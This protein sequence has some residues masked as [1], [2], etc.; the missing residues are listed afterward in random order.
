MTVNRQFILG[1]VLVAVGCLWLFLILFHIKPLFLSLFFLGVWLKASSGFA[2]IVTFVSGGEYL[3]AL[4]TVGSGL[5]VW[6]RGATGRWPLKTIFVVLALLIVG[7]GTRFAIKKRAVQKREAAYQFAVSEYQRALRPGMTRKEAEDYLG[8]KNV[9]F[10]QMCCVEPND[11]AKRHTWDD[12]VKIGEEEHPWF[13]TEHYVY[14]AFQFADHVQIE[15]GYS[16][17]DDDSDILKAVSIFHQ[18]GGCL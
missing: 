17:T 5:T 13:C 10:T 14:V 7:T 18:L 6:R 11:L 16:M 3:A 9:T 1:K 12:L 4:A 15:N 2:E 8:A